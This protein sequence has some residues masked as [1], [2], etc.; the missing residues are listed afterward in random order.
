MRRATLAP[1]ITVTTVA[2]PASTRMPLANTRRRPRLVR[3]DG[4]KW[5]SAWKLASRGKSANDVFAASTRM[6][7]V[8]AWT[9]K[10]AMF[11]NVPLPIT[12]RG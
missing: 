11:P 1:K 10:K 9:M 8:I 12:D 3:G 4:R 5:S 2:R 6:S 7:T